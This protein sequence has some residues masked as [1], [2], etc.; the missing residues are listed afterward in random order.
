LLAEALTNMARLY[1][2]MAEHSGETAKRTQYWIDARSLYQR[3]QGLWR[4]LEKA[5][6]LPSGRG[7]AA[8]K[9]NTE[10]ARCNESLA[11]LQQVQ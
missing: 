8:Q 6:K 9:I 4:E 2:Y 7:D 1:E 10:L 3:S 5:G 11:K